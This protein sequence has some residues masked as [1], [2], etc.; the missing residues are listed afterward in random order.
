MRFPALLLTLAMTAAA[1]GCSGD[2]AGPADNANPEAR[3]AKAA[4][5]SARRHDESSYSEPEKVRIA[6]LA[7]DL[8]LDFDS[9]TLSGTATYALE[10]AKKRA[11]IEEIGR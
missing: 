9:R 5:A 7:L 10:W 11:G 6:D 4:Q 8:E 1:S 2:K 3:P